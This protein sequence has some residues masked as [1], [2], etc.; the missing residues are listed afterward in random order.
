MEGAVAQRSESSLHSILD[1][2][3]GYFLTAIAAI[4]AS[5]LGLFLVSKGVA[6]QTAMLVSV[7]VA[8]IGGFLAEGSIRLWPHEKKEL[9]I[10]RNF[11]DLVWRQKPERGK[12]KIADTTGQKGA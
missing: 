5:V 12:P 2:W 1:V 11:K 8:V 10:F 7:G 9:V 3:F 4:P 6:N